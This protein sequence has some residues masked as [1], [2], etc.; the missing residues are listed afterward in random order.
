MKKRLPK[1][2]VIVIK[3]M[4]ERMK[5]RVK[6]LCRETEDFSV[7]VRIYKDSALST[8]LF[9]LVID[10]ITND[11]QRKYHCASCLQMI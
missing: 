10:E 6:K 7:R 3:D 1:E 11:F 2:Y 8:Y 5:K 9:N 4:Y